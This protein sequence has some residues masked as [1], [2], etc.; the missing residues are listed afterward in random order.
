MRAR[1]IPREPIR[2][3][4]VDIAAAVRRR[5]P[6]RDRHRGH[7]RPRRGRGARGGRR[8]CCRRAR[9]TAGGAGPRGHRHPLRRRGVGPVSLLRGRQ[10]PGIRRVAQGGSRL[11][12][13]R[14]DADP[15]TRHPVPRDRGA[16]RRRRGARDRRAGR[17]QPRLLPEA[18]RRR[19]PAATLRARGLRR[20]RAPAGESAGDRDTGRQAQRARLLRSLTRQPPRRL[21]HFAGRFGRFGAAG[22]RGRD[23][24]GAGRRNR[25]RAVRRA[26][27]AA[28]RA[29]RL[30]PAAEARRRGAA[31]RPVSEFARLRP[32]ARRRAG[33]RRR[34]VR[35]RRDAARRDRARR[36]RRRPSPAGLVARG[37]AGDQRRAAR[38]QAVDGAAGRARR[39]SIRP[40]SGSSTRPTP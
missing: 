10:E 18:A 2:A 33:P 16:R 14:A 15:R 28:G 39:C 22:H 35:R 26:V 21:R 29:A 20:Q 24:Q 25:P 1:A 37:G 8:D 12:A 9:Q 11:R 40:G 17:R 38:V 36:E 27:V 30:H 4:L 19:E 13:R 34:A 7:R 3:L 23:R 5:H 31:D 32:P 6:V